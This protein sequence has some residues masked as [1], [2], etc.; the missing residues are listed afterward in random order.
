MDTQLIQVLEK[1]TQKEGGRIYLPP[2]IAIQP[3]EERD[4][5]FPSHVTLT[6][7]KSGAV[8]LP[9]KPREVTFR[10][11]AGRSPSKTG[12]LKK[13]RIDFDLIKH[14]MQITCVAPVHFGGTHVDHTVREV[15]LVSATPVCDG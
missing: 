8:R 1:P 11:S 5:H 13:L 15:P 10:C 9:Q 6:L 12:P 14:A 4:M 2:S 7:P 3:N